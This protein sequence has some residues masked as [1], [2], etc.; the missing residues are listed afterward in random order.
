VRPLDKGKRINVAN[1]NRD[2]TGNIQPIV[3]PGEA[4]CRVDCVPFKATVT[5][6]AGMIR[7]F[8]QDITGVFRLIGEVATSAATPSGTVASWE[9]TWTPPAG[10]LTLGP[11]QVLGAST[12]NAEEVIAF[13]EG[14]HF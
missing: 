10:Y 12:H 7:I 6:T 13:P 2:G 14:G 5:T 4:G 3:V 11:T 8:V 9:G 1:T